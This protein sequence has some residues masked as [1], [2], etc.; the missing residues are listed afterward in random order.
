MESIK[1]RVQPIFRK[2]FKND[3]LI[4]APEMTADDVE[5]WDSLN[6]LIMVREVEEEFKIKFKLKELVNMKN[7][8]DLLNLIQS[9]TQ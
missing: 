3:S 1:E 8:G 9:K 6:H 7:V 5:K 4:I 2:V